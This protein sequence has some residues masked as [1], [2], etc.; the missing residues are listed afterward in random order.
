MSPSNIPRTLVQGM[1]R[2][3]SPRTFFVIV[4]CFLR[5]GLML[6]CDPETHYR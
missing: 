2:L 6:I 4:D 1:I 3:V 5:Q